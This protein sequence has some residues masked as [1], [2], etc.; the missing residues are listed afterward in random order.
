MLF[1]SRE[2]NHDLI[3]RITELPEQELL[4]HLSTLKES[5]LLY[6]RGNYPQSTYIFRHALTRE[7]VYDSI[8]V[9]NRKQLH[10]KIGSTIETLYPDKRD[11]H[12]GALVKHF[13]AGGNYRKTADYSRLACLKAEKSI[14]LHEA[15]DYGKKLIEA[16][17]QLPQTEKLQDEI[18]D[19]RTTLGFYLF[20]MSSMAEAKECIDPISDAI[21]KRGNKNRV[22]QAYV[23]IGSFKYMSEENFPK[24]V[25]YLEKAIE[26]SEETRDL[27]TGVYAKYMLGLVLAMNCDY[28]KA[29]PY[30]E[31]LLS[32]SI[33]MQFP[34]QISVMKSNLSV[35]AYDYHGMVAQGYQTSGDAVRIAEESGDRS[36]E[37]RVGKECR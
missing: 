34:W 2:F 11:E 5:E 9:K 37:R 33:A 6:E 26:T 36:E 3:K 23:I 14:S 27:V 22:G 19:A 20:R 15:T 32:L 35:Y 1:R 28:E 12:Y 4:S 10:E 21:L 7:V 25:E 24:S 8:L 17:E 18:I 29:I 16:L 13:M 31:G 30:F